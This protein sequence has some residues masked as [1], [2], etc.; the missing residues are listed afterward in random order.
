MIITRPLLEANVRITLKK[1][2]YLVGGSEY[3][4]ICYENL[5]K[6]S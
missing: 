1:K 5:L 3:V 4:K 2:S 6:H